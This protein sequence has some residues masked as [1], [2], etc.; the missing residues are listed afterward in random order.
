[1]AR[2]DGHPLNVPSGPLSHY[3]HTH[4]H[5]YDRS[6][7]VFFVSCSSVTQE[8]LWEG[9]LPSQGASVFWYGTESYEAHSTPPQNP[10]PQNP[11]PQNPA[12]QNPSPQNP[13]SE[14][15]APQRNEAEGEEGHLEG[16]TPPQSQ[17]KT[18]GT[19]RDDTKQR[20]KTQREN[21]KKSS[22]LILR[23]IFGAKY[24]H[25]TSHISDI[26]SIYGHCYIGFLLNSEPGEHQ[27]NGGFVA[28]PN[29]F[30]GF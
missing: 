23:D 13:A 5:T 6:L 15:P 11:A 12:P 7:F 20:R 24:Q 26:L 2:A 16:I 4:K 25:K 1:M 3:T 9:L 30:P 28:H 29:I 18:K 17:N 10:A 8:A 21:E 19:G 14:N 27:S 22:S